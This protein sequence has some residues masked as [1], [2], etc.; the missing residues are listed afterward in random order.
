MPARE[1]LGDGTNS[2]CTAATN[3]EGTW[4]NACV[5]ECEDA[6]RESRA[7]LV[8]RGRTVPIEPVGYGQLVVGVVLA[9]RTRSR[10]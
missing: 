2:G 1:G 7:C 6:R 3:S 9:R 5:P 8:H 4:A 10:R